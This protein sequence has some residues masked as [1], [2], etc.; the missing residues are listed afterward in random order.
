MWRDEE[1][2][3]EMGMESGR[4]WVCH[5]SHSN[6]VSMFGLSLLLFQIKPGQTGS[7]T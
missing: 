3:K 7:P 2:W 6:E 1:R 5:A 4:I